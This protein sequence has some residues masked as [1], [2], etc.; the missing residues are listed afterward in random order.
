MSNIR[1]FR[2]GHAVSVLVSRETDAGERL[3]PAEVYIYDR[4][5]RDRDACAPEVVCDAGLTED[6]TDQALDLAHDALPAPSDDE[7]RASR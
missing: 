6:E 2:Y 7:Y 4:H 3:I 1:Q 5:P